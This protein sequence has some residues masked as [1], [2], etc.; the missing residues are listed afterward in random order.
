[1][2]NTH[3]TPSI[4]PLLLVQGLWQNK[5]L[6][7]QMTKRDIAIRYRGSVFG[8]AWSFVT[9]ILM[10]VVYTFVFS[11]VFGARW[12]TSSS[13]SQTDFA[14]ILFVGM[15][16]YGFFAEVVNKSP[17]LII[18]NVNYV[19][20]VVF[21][22]EILPVISIG[23]TLFHSFIS[24]LVLIVALLFTKG[25]VQLT[26]V[27]FPLIFLPLVIWTLGVVWF[28]A[29]LGVFIRD[30]GQ[31]VVLLTT[32]IMFLSPVFYPVSALPENFQKLLYYNPLTF[33]IEQSRAVIIF[34]QFPDWNGLAVYALVSLFVAWC[35]FCC[36]QR[37]RQGFADVL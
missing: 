28:V 37:V 12:G 20:K 16:V 10:L 4:S 29:A 8:I 22:L 36:F 7:G 5:H 21:P 11:V 35:G 14:I 26:A 25:E 2:K 23:A 30:L 18:A 1:M 27:F 24:G 32:A 15:I 17:T 34:G 19:K 3:A 33:V 31:A 6:I 13:E 9:P